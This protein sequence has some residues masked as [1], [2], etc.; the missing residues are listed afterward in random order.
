MFVDDRDPVYSPSDEGRQGFAQA[1]GGGDGQ[2]GGDFTRPEAV[3]HRVEPEQLDAD[4][5]ARR[6]ATKSFAGLDKISGVF[7]AERRD[8]GRARRFCPPGVE[9]RRCH[10]SPARS[11][12][13]R[14]PIDASD[15][16]L[17]RASGHRIESAEQGSS[18]S[19]MSGSP[20]R[21]RQLHDPLLLSSRQ[22]MRIAVSIDLG[23]KLER[24][25]QFGHAIARARPRPLEQIRHGRN[26]LLYRPMGE[27]ADRLDG[28][29]RRSSSGKLR[30][31]W[32]AKRMRPL[33]CSSRRLIIFNALDLPDPESADRDRELASREWSARGRRSP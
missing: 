29:A 22:L 23:R 32:P 28:V 31:S 13:R 11:S 21:A 20:A 2:A 12:C 15:L 19:S 24:L 17:Q 4:I 7:R 9:L 16:L 8:H 26:V 33:S 14:R 1:R 30:I 25:Q 5:A 27:Q 6:S 18:M 3:G 10:A